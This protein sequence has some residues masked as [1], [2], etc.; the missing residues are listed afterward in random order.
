MLLYLRLQNSGQLLQGFVLV[1]VGIE[2]VVADV[3]WLL[4]MVEVAS[5]VK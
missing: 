2:A 3:E 5:P 4:G 1:K